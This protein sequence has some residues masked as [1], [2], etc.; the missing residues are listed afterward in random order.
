MNTWNYRVVK[1][2]DGED[3]WYQIHSAYYDNSELTGLSAN[4][5][6]PCGN[7][8]EQLRNDLQKMLDALDK[9]IIEE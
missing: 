3:D 2:K 5:A 6:S 8:I 1:S 4:G 7:T 9:P